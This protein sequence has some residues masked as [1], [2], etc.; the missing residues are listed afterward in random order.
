M[1]T[2]VDKCHNFRNVTACETQNL[3][4]NDAKKI[5]LPIG[6]VRFSY[7]S[8]DFEG[9]AYEMCCFGLVRNQKM[10]LENLNA[11]PKFVS[12]FPIELPRI[13]EKYSSIMLFKHW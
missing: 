5:F 9:S 13:G 4:Q 2:S 11:T 3:W 1:N 6:K 10:N 12:T 7:M 8:I